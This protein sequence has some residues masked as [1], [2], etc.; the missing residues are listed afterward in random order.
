MPLPI[1]HSYAGYAIYKGSQKQSRQSGFKWLVFLMILANLPDLD[2]LPGVLLGH[3]SHFHRGVSHSLGFAV[4]AAFASALALKVFCRKPFKKM[5]GVCF[6]AC[7]S[8]AVLDSFTGSSRAIFWPLPFSGFSAFSG[9]HMDEHVMF[10]AVSGFSDFLF[11][12]SSPVFIGRVLGE[13]AILAAL[14]FMEKAVVL[15]REGAMPQL[16]RLATSAL[17]V[18]VLL[19]AIAV[20]AIAG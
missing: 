16:R 18:A 10:G 6:V 17:F 5:L 2:F 1:L 20:T 14:L 8:H 13:T 3:A 15:Y 12:L 11:M 4:L 9:L 7:F 19:G